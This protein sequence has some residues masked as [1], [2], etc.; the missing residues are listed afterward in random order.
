MPRN[1]YQ[2]DRASMQTHT[3]TGM[4]TNF[5]VHDAFATE[6]Q[7]PVQNRTEENLVS[8]DKAIVAARKLILNGIRDVQAGPGAAA[9]DTRCQGECFPQSGGDLRCDCEIDGLERVHAEPRA[10]VITGNNIFP[11]RRKD[12][13]VTDTMKNLTAMLGRSMIAISSSY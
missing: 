11:Q 13:K 2:Q 9:C 4:G 7:G 10:E 6:S 12:A 5:Q 3:F 1:R 8:S